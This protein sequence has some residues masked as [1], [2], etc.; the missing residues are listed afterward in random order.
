MKPL[1]SLTCLSRGVGALAGH[2]AG[3]RMGVGLATSGSTPG[4]TAAAGGPAAL[5]VAGAVL[6]DGDAG[7]QRRAPRAGLHPEDLRRE[8]GRD[9]RTGQ[10]GEGRGAPAK[11]QS[12]FQCELRSTDSAPLGG[13]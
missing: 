11:Q 7:H 2:S 13:G 8:T 6:L 3:P 9:G 10:G 12:L 4:R 1:G 5:H